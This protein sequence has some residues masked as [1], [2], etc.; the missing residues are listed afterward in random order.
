MRRRW[1]NF[2]PD[3]YIRSLP[4]IK[5]GETVQL[6]APLQNGGIDARK[7]AQAS[8]SSIR[9]DY[10]VITIRRISSDSIGILFDRQEEG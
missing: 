5:R 10:G 1:I 4:A 3:C 9:S 2:L 7:T 6:A 8:H